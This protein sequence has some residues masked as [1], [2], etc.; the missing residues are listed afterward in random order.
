MRNWKS[1][2]GAGKMVQ[3]VRML[4]L[5]AWGSEF[6]SP[7]PQKKSTWLQRPVTPD[8]LF[9][10]S[11]TET[12]ESQGYAWLNQKWTNKNQNNEKMW[13]FGSLWEALSVWDTVYERPCFSERDPVYKR[14]C[15]S[16]R[17]P[18]CLQE[19]LSVCDRPCFKPMMQWELLPWLHCEHTRLWPLSQW[20]TCNTETQRKQIYVDR[21]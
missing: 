8:H 14:S 10:V 9:P 20:F 16:A 11:G 4:D 17:D 5:W 13:T 1:K 18:V 7:V 2:L 3:W 12:C 19:T 15:L 21:S 6:E